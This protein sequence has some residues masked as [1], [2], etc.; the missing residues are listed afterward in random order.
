MLPANE[1]YDDSPVATC[2]SALLHFYCASCL[3]LFLYKKGHYKPNLAANQRFYL[4]FLF[5]R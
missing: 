5:A 2:A 4:P 1:P 3:Q